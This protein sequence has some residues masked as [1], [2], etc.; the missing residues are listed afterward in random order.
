MRKSLFLIFVICILFF[1]CTSAKLISNVEIPSDKETIYLCF[2]NTQST[3]ESGGYLIGNMFFAGVD[4]ASFNTL[5][6]RILAKNILTEK[7]YKI[8]Q[9]IENADMILYAGCE[10]SEIQSVVTILL[11]DAKTEAEYVTTKGSYGMG[12]DLKGDMKGALKNALQS[13]PNK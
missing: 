8:S 4:T 6:N 2:D 1:G 9:K 12:I 11:V 7:G 13:I 5:E 10:S 3:V